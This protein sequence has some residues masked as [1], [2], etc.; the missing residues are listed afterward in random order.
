MTAPKKSKPKK[1]RAEKYDNKVSVKGS[2]MDIMK[3]SAD[4]AKKN[5]PKK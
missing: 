4:H 1:K 2:F 3:A 5:H